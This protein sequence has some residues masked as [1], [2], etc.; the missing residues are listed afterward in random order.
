MSWKEN[1]RR[2]RTWYKHYRR[3]AK[4]VSNLLVGSGGRDIAAEAIV[5][6][7]FELYESRK[8]HGKK[9]IA[10]SAYDSMLL[11]CRDA[12]LDKLTLTRTVYLQRPPG[13]YGE[14]EPRVRTKP[15]KET[16]AGVDLGAAEDVS[17][18][19]DKNRDAQQT[20]TRVLDRKPGVYIN[21]AI[22]DPAPVYYK[23]FDP[24]PPRSATIIGVTIPAGSTVWWEGGELKVSTPDDSKPKDSQP[25]PKELSL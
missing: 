8:L 6:L 19:V 3:V 21:Q 18:V 25:M 2:S 5:N 23:D 9:F 11:A 1:R 17:V 20:D 12:G 22:F 10:E 24:P 14:L 13:R 16:F 4:A 15:D 7:F